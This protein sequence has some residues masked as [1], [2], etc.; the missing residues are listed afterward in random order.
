MSGQF[1]QN[2]HAAGSIVCAW[3]REGTVAFIFVLVCD[4]S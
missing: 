3:H 4:V 1:E 2:S